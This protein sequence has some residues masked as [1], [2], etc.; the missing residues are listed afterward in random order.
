M[1]RRSLGAPAKMIG[2]STPMKDLRREVERVA[3]TELAVLILGETGTGKDLVARLIHDRS[4]RARGPFVAENCSAIA[5][6]LMESELF[7]HKKGAFTGADVDRE[8]LF[9]LASGG[10]LFLDEIGDM[11]LELQAKLLRALQEQRIRRVGESRTIPVDIRLVAATHKDIKAATKEGTFRED[12]YFRI[13]A[14]ELKVPPLRDRGKDILLLARDFLARFNKEHGRKLELHKKVEEQLLAYPW[15]GNVRELQ[16]VIARAAIL[17]EGE[18][19]EALDLPEVEAEEKTASPTGD[20]PA[21]SRR[22][23]QPRAGR[24]PRRPGSWASPA[25]PSTRS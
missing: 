25:P 1:A 12:L 14:V 17:A 13:A 11:P 5:A 4:S 6:D 20:W 23:W 3:A 9:E 19:I 8:G 10:T 7:G 22:R 21:R 2:E 18:R 15:P 24:R 16:H